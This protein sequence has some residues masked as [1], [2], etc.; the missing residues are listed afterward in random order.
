MVS[1]ANVKFKLISIYIFTVIYIYNYKHKKIY[2]TYIYIYIHIQLFIWRIRMYKITGCNITSSQGD[3]D[4]VEPSFLFQSGVK[5]ISRGDP[6]TLV[7][8]SAMV[9]SAKG[10]AKRN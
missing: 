3:H 9:G 2:I 10:A 8:T 6:V 1:V 4:D 5:G 7:I